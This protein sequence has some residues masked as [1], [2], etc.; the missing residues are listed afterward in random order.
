MLEIKA[1]AAREGIA[2]RL[3]VYD[4]GSMG[5]CPTADGSSTEAS[6]VWARHGIEHR[7]FDFAG[8]PKHVSTLHCYAWKAP[9]VV[10][11]A[12]EVGN[13]SVVMWVDSGATVLSPL[14]AIIQDARNDGFV[15]DDTALSLA[16]FSHEGMLDFFVE[17]FGLSTAVRDDLV[18]KRR[19]GE[20]RLDK[21]DGLGEALHKFKNCN[22][23]F[24]AHVFGSKLYEAISEKWLV[25]SLS[26]DCVCPAGSSRSN[27][28]QDQAALTMLA[29]QSDYV[30]GARGKAVSAHGMRQPIMGILV[31]HGAA[32]QDQDQKRVFCASRS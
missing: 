12:K 11:V 15:S 6:A 25:C 7:V 5:A 8:Y 26:R 17:K 2:V 32:T 9:C 28:R 24:S 4:L 18:S 29:L 22:G 13:S 14:R 27:H 10:A 30:C 20:Q 19:A 3:I 16:R 31:K 1:K 21:L 23:A